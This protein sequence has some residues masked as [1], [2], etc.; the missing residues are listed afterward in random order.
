[1]TALM[2]PVQLGMT[3]VA[4]ELLGEIDRHCRA[5]LAACC[6]RLGI[7]RMTCHL[8]VLPARDYLVIHVQGLESD[9]VLGRLAASRQPFERWL[10]AS[11]TE[12]TGLDVARSEAVQWLL[13][14][15]DLH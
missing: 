15:A 13:P 11:L 4:R 2:L 7:E 14:L 5:E 6:E 9:L 10:Y 12:L 3:Q 8:A 1:M